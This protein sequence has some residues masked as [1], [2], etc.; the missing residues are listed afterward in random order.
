M[1]SV[2]PGALV[3]ELPTWGDFH[4]AHPAALQWLLELVFSVAI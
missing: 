2:Q 1:A 4:V 3:A